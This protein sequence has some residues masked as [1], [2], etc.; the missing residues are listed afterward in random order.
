MDDCMETLRSVV[1]SMSERS[2]AEADAD[3]AGR[4]PPALAGVWASIS[5]LS[6]A[7]GR[8]KTS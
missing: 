6:R 8:L 5:S 4:R 2:V 3:A 7:N 1:M